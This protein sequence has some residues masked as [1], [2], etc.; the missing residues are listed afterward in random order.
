MRVYG[1]TV[2][3]VI[4][5]VVSAIAQVAKSALPK[6]VPPNYRQLIVQDMKTTLTTQTHIHNAQIS[7][8]EVSTGLFAVPF[9]EITT[10]CVKFNATNIFGNEIDEARMYNFADGKLVSS[11]PIS[12]RVMYWRWCDSKVYSRFQTFDGVR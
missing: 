3:F 10:F 1:Y 5:G 11:G 8:P 4:L 12:G 9:G 2:I 7:N 6:G